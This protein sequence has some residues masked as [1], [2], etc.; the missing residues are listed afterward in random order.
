M[1]TFLYGT[2]KEQEKSAS[3]NL[4]YPSPSQSIISNLVPNS[5]LYTY[6]KITQYRGSCPNK[7]HLCQY[8]WFFPGC[9]VGVTNYTD[10]STVLPSLCIY[11]R[12]ALYITFQQT[13]TTAKV[14]IML[15]PSI[16]NC[17][18]TRYQEK[19]QV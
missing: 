9:P 14:C 1:S 2:E 18:Y 4:Q 17:I 6:S 19:E 7:M 8:S 16:G 5:Y 11:S 10:E 3:I 13:G 15:I 12:R